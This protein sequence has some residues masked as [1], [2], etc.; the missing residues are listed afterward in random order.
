MQLW[1]LLT[2]LSAAKGTDE[3]GASVDFVSLIDN[4]QANIDE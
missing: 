3:G 2:Y 1:D 4:S